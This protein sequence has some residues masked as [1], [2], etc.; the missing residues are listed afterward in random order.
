MGD[1]GNIAGYAVAR[2]CHDGWKVGPL[3]A[4]SDD[5]ATSLLASIAAEIRGE[6]YIDVPA[7]QDTFTK[8][9]R[10]AGLEA[11]FQTTRMYAGSAPHVQ[12]RLVF[13]V[14]SLELG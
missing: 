8:K 10:N 13:G 12:A 6:L 4:E 9:L 11:G 3:F 14:T 1:S 2:Q 7:Y 5:D